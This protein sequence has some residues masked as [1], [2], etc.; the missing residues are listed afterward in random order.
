MSTD[1]TGNEQKEFLTIAEA[2]ET[3]GCT[4]RFL[5]K[6]IANDEIATFHPSARLIRIR[7]IELER[8]ISRFTHEI[9]EAR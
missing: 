4:R 6:R 8:W 5:E 2:A 1:A 9:K 7:R 3:I